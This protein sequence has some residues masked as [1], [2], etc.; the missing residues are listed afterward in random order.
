MTDPNVRLRNQDEE[1]DDD[2]EFLDAGCMSSP[3][4]LSG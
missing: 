1:D 3:Q 4:Q 2:D